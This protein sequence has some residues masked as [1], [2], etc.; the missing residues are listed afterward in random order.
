MP[1]WACTTGLDAA[2]LAARLLV[3]AVAV[4]GDVAALDLDHREA[5]ARPGDEQ[6][7]LLL[8][9]PSSRPTELDAA[10]LSGSCS[11]SASHTTASAPLV[12][13]VGVAGSSAAR[14]FLPRAESAKAASSTMGG[15]GVLRRDRPLEKNPAVP[16]LS[17]SYDVDLIEELPD[18][19]RHL[20]C[21]DCDHRWHHGEV[22]PAAVARDPRAALRDRFPSGHERLCRAG[23][24]SSWR[25]SKRT[26]SADA[27]AQPR[28]SVLGE[29][30]GRSEP[31]GLPLCDP[32]DLKAFANNSTGANPG[33]MA[34]FNTA[35][36][37]LGG[38]EAAGRTRE[39]ISYLLYGPE[40]TPLEDRLTRLIRGG[41]RR[42][43]ARLP[44][45]PADSR[46]SA[47]SCPTASCRSS[48]Y[49]TDRRRQARILLARWSPGSSCRR[50]SPRRTG[51]SAG[52]PYWSNDLLLNF[53]GRGLRQQRATLPSSCG[54]SGRRCGADRARL[55]PGAPP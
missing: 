15:D 26:S 19:R 54:S 55:P 29:V 51:R 38:A 21:E 24:G 20:V 10:R 53:D 2:A 27:L 31:D 14:V 35:W 4:A 41:P 12:A 48:G 8:P 7:D 44:R 49:T 22:R 5:D 36:N 47:S 52:W 32:A 23:P 33:N 16:P 11:R 46:S 34:A 18:G 37:R 17:D 1:S 43:D 3:P 45:E 13:E 6:V 50:R 42:G 40:A 39:T 25:R 30:P 28:T 9:P